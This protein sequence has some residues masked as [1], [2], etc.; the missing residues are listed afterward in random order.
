MYLTATEE[1]MYD[2]E[3]GEAVEK[4]MKILVAL[5]DI[6]G[7]EKMVKISSAQ[8]SGVSYKTIGDAGLEYLEELSRDPSARVKVQS[9][10]NPAG[11]DL[12]KWRELGFSREFADR[13]YRIIDA[14]MRMDVMNTCTCT[15]YLIGNIPTSGSHVAWSESSAVVYANSV[16]GARTNREGGPGALAAAICGRTPAYGYHL[17][18]NRIANIL[19]KVEEPIEGYEYGVLGHFIGKSVGE[20]VPC[21]QLPGRP[22][23]D[24]FKSLGAALASSGAIALYYVEGLTRDGDGYEFEDKI[25]VDGT[26]IKDLK[27]ELSTTNDKPD[28]VCVGCPHCSLNEIRALAHYLRGGKVSCD[29]WVCTSYALKAAADRMGYTG[30][31]EDSGGVLVSDTCMVVSP[32]EDLGFEVIGVDSAKAANY[33]PGMCG[34][35]VVFDDWKTLIKL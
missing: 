8:I 30:L 15:P 11:M 18:E 31:I 3:Y 1:K 6:Y 27:D 16:L 4:S 5:G 9:S 26:V 32:V 2:G 19:V 20:G 24:E 25:S 22:S 35:D 10:L 21:F 14:Y 34:V 13:Q 23:S 12:N 29:L 17:D 7:A 28:L 33:I